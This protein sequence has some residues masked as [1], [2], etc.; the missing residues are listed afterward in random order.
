MIE[1]LGV[2]GVEGDWKKKR[3]VGVLG[4]ELEKIGDKVGG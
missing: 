3:I 1:G 2:V 4:W